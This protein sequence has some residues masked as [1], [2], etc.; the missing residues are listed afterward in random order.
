MATRFAKTQIMRSLVANL[1]YPTVA[2][3][4]FDEVRSDEV[5]PSGL[6]EALAWKSHAYLVLN[7]EL[8]STGYDCS[9]DRMR[10]DNETRTRILDV[11]INLADTAEGDVLEFGVY[12]GESLEA[13]AKK[14]PQRTV[15]GFD[16]FKGLPSSWWA[17]PKGAFATEMPRHC[18]PNV[19]IIQGLFDDTLPQFLAKWHGRAAIVHVDCDLYTSTRS[20]LLHIVPRLQEKAVI[21]FDEYYNYPDFARHEWLAWREIRSRYRINASCVAYDGRRAAFQIMN[22]GDN[23]SSALQP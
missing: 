2:M 3:C 6:V 21:L 13:F 14:C 4:L 12:K 5:S 7:E 17:R 15:Y 18:K 16:S 20:A 22:V 11:V 23:S 19:R 8:A 9:S 10:C 1:V